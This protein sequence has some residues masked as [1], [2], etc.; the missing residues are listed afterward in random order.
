MEYGI[1]KLSEVDGDAVDQA[2]AI[3]VDGLYNVLSALSKDKEVLKE[4]F[5]ESF[6]Y[7]L[8]YACLHNGEAVGFVGIGNSSKRPASNMKIETFERLL[9]K[10]A[11]MIYKFAA[12]PFSKPRM[13]NENTVEIE[14]LATA[15]HFRGK[16]VA[17]QLI[18]YVCDNL[19]YEHCVL[20]VYS[21]NP[22]AIRLY[23]HLGFR[24]VGIKSEWMLRLR[25]IGKTITM[26]LDIKESKRAE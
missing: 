7:D 22:T 17:T 5:K 26:K 9:G 25:G 12:P 1:L 18:K 11:R 8:V 24:Q 20:D 3:F 2:T 19:D 13:D 23:E 4:L 14:F 6:Q 15:R 21:K 10:N 16:G